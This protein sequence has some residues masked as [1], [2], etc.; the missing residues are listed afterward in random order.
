[1]EHIR[2]IQALTDPMEIT[3]ILLRLLGSDLG[4]VSNNR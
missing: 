2:C 1:M 3:A 4:L